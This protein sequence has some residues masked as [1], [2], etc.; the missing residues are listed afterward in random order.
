MNIAASIGAAKQVVTSKAGLALLTGQKHSPAILFGV[1]V[2][3]V[4]ATVVM[5][6]RATLKVSEVLDAFEEKKEMSKDLREER[7]ETYTEDKFKHDQVVIHTRLV[8]DI[9]KLYAPSVVVG[10]LSVAALGGA[11]VILTRRNAA[12]TATLTAVNKAFNEYRGRVREELGDDKDREFMYGTSTREEIV[13][14]KKGSKVEKV[15]TFGDGSSPYSKVFD[16]ENYNFQNTVEGNGWFIRLIQNHCNDRLRAKGYLLLNDVY[17]ELGM[18]DT[19]AGCVVGWMWD[20]ENGDQYIDFGCWKDAERGGL[21]PFHVGAD[22]SILLDFNVDGPIFK[23][24]GNS[25]K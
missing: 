5:S 21:D 10:C 18:D 20:S 11:P 19:E 6:S 25:G 7:P 22:G 17:R 16:A 4:V 3:G 13:E 15:T 1:G 9:T 24:L 23:K 12:L 8:L 14:T 2:A